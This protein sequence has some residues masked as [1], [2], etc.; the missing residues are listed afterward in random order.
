MALLPEGVA[1]LEEPLA[2]LLGLL[3]VSVDGVIAVAPAWGEFVET[4]GVML[5][6]ALGTFREFATVGKGICLQGEATVI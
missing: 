4:A 1:A 2:T 6:E 3:L 5:V